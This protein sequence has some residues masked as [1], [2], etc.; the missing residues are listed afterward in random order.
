MVITSQQ[1]EAILI[2]PMAKRSGR[3][4]M[5]KTIDKTNTILNSFIFSLVCLSK[6]QV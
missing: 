4:V 2:R 5:G 6:H 1:N 3:Q